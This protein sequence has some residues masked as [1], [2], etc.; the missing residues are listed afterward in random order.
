[1]SQ[2]DNVIENYLDSTETYA[3]QID[4]KWGVGKTYYLKN[5]MKQKSSDDELQ[6][7]YFSLYG[8]SDLVELKK[9]LMLKIAIELSG[10]K[11]LK[12]G[13]KA[14]G[15]LGK[16]QWN[17]IFYQSATVISNYI[18][19]QIN[20]N[21]LKKANSKIV[22]V[23]DDLERIST[24]IHIEDI[25]GFILNDLLEEL[26]VKVII[27]SNSSEIS[28]NK[29]KKI[30]EKVIGRTVNFSYNGEDLREIVRYRAREGF[31]PNNIDWIFDIFIT[32]FSNISEVNIRTIFSII[33][34]F[35]FIS[36]KLNIEI[37]RLSSE[38]QEQIQKS[39][40]LNVFVITNE[41]KLGKISL[42]NVADLKVNDFD[43]GFFIWG[44]PD[45]QNLFHNLINKYH[46]TMT[47]FDEYIIYADMI[48]NYIVNGVWDDTG[49]V[50]RWEEVFYPVRMTTA[51]EQLTDFRRMTDSE[52]E[53]L[54]VKI[55]QEVMQRNFS[56]NELVDI[57]SRFLQ[58]QQI[59][60]LFIE[61][62][63]LELL[64]E[65][66]IRFI[67]A[68]GFSNEILESYHDYLAFSSIIN[69]PFK[70]RMEEILK[71]QREIFEKKRNAELVKAIF[72]DNKEKI[73]SITDYTPSSELN[74]FPYLESYIVTDIVCKQSK[75]DYLVS[76]I[77][78]EYLRVY[79]SRDFHSKE[80]PD[81][82]EF[83]NNI[84][85][86]VNNIEIE[87]VDKYK[88]GQLLEVLEK[89]KEHLSPIS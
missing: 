17:N 49:Y 25:L 15:F 39:L 58:F 73:K 67:G 16:I 40:F 45:E 83:M 76:Y 50:G 44:D 38:K 19:E 85:V 9:D 60:L 89:L 7:I 28:G 66:I 88:I 10:G 11:L 4:G 62:Q 52:I 72:L 14:L 36:G 75:A 78:R 86:A 61:Q 43:R 70:G 57:Y 74:I 3:L 41:Y 18:L 2:I 84:G 63:E 22:I 26:S 56:F 79:N 33:D 82:M 12:Q 21:Q 65:K 35:E 48:N 31:I 24:N 69:Q 5:F 47:S 87:R 13:N 71:R 34:N 6:Y 27:V 29:Y 23:I 53:S 55:M 8:Y 64:E 32:F 77:N 42:D 30:K 37:G 54:Q 80:I 68:N 20:Q 51:Y 1:M 46:K 81:I 59:D